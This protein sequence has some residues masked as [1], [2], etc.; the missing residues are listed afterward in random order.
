VNRVPGDRR[1]RRLFVAVALTTVAL[2]GIVRLVGRLAQERAGGAVAGS[3]EAADEGA[4]PQDAAMVGD[5]SF[6]K[7]LGNEPAGRRP[8]P[9]DASLKLGPGDLSSGGG[10]FVVQVLATGDEAQAQR[11]RE[12][13]A[14]KGFQATTLEDDSGSNVVWRVRVGRWKERASAETA[15]EKIRT[16][17][18]LE[19]W[20]LREAGR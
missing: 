8:A 2:L 15:A 14:R 19:A 11:V 1:G 10:V 17:T 7:R 16:Q 13:L 9:P 6:Y 18:G 20:V 3:R 4:G 5:L 12:G